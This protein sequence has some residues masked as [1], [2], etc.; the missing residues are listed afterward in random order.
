MYTNEHIKRFQLFKQQLAVTEAQPFSQPALFTL[1]GK[2]GYIQL[3]SINVT[4]ARSQ[5]IFLWSRFKDYRKAS[6][7]D[8]YNEGDAVEVYLNALSL[9]LKDS[10]LV[11]NLHQMNLTKLQN[12]VNY[13]DYIKIYR[14]LVQVGRVYKKDF[15]TNHSLPQWEISKEDNVIDKLWRG[16]H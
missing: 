7:V 2:I 4:N 15:V 12:D 11:Q 6:Y 1:L 3:D 10:Q 5:D 8:A 9:M 13:S 16:T 14:Q